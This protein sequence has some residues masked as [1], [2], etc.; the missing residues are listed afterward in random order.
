MEA[1]VDEVDKPR[2]QWQ[3]RLILVGLVLGGLVWG[4]AI[5][6]SVTSDQPEALP[7]ADY[8][9]LTD[10]CGA[11]LGD[12]RALPDLEAD[13]DALEAVALIRAENEVFDTMVAQLRTVEPDGDAGVALSKWT[14]DWETVIERRAAYADELEASGEGRF[15]SP[16][17][18]VLRIGTYAE[19]QGLDDCTPEAMQPD[20]VDRPRAYADDS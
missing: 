20:V 11:T 6:Y 5:W 7:D 13:S 3:I 17:E 2:P 15:G 19:V 8:A 16:L 1:E 9:T 10:I 4:F 12:L 14:D 18:I